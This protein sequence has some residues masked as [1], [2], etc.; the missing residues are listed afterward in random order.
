MEHTTSAQPSSLLP[1]PAKATAVDQFAH[2]VSSGKVAFFQAAGI[3]FVLGRREGPYMW[4][5]DGRTRLINCH[6]NGGVFNLGHRH[7]VRVQTLVESLQELDIGDHHLVSAP[8]A[9]LAAR[10]AELT[11]GLVYSVF[12]AG[13]GEAI[14][15]AIKVARGYTRRQKIIS[16]AGGYHGHTGFALYTGDEKYFAPFGP[17]LP[18]YVQIPFGD[19]EALAAAIDGDTAAVILETIPATLGMPIAT[20]SYYPRVREL[21]DRHGALL[22]L[23][24]I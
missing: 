5:L 10:L 4:D 19:A 14:D 24:E 7:P 9:T 22:I 18:G 1:D 16:A 6:C 2:H 15:L 8:R 13:G 20:P 17:R 12:A 23:D 11:P 3:D 21:C